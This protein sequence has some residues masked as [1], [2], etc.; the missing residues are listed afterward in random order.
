T[1]AKLK[2]N[3]VIYKLIHNKG[4]IAVKFVDKQRLNRKNTHFKVFE[5]FSQVFLRKDFSGVSRNK[6]CS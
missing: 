1:R 2:K 3:D 5:E 6:N 4:R